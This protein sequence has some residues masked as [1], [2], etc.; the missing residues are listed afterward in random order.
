M[1]VSHLT[2]PPASE[3]GD[4]APQNWR[5]RQKG[6]VDEMNAGQIP[7]MGNVMRDATNALPEQQKRYAADMNRAMDEA[8]SDIAGGAE[9]E[10]L[11]LRGYSPDALSKP[12]FLSA[13]RDLLTRDITKMRAL[14]QQ[15]QAEIVRLRRMVFEL[16]QSVRSNEDALDRLA[17]NEG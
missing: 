8:A 2:T 7:G 11:R 10:A 3:P 16:T 15:H 12:S 1:M 4:E 17:E 6:Y 14:K 5:Q 13:R 9:A